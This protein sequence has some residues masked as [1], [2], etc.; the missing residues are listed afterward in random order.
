MEIAQ[1]EKRRFPR[2]HLRTPIRYQIRGQ[3]EFDNTVSENISTGGIG[4]TTSKFIPPATALMLEINLLSRFLRPIG[5]IAWVSPLP[6]S[7]RNRVGIEFIELDATEK[8][9]LNDY[10]NMQTQTL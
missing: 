1:N 6:H 2:I 9:F 4:F 10:I 8:N 5:E 7:D 3:P